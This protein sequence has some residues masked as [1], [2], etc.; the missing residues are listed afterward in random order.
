MI[1]IDFGPIESATRFLRAA[2]S[3]KRFASSKTGAGGV[4]R[5]AGGSI[6]VALAVAGDIGDKTSDAKV[7]ETKIEKRLR[8]LLF[9]SNL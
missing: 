5:I 6:V 3:A 9:I 8:F 7:S 4:T 2:N 1:K